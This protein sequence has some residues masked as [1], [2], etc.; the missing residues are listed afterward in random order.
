LQVCLC[1][2]AVLVALELDDVILG[3]AVLEVLELGSL[4][5]HHPGCSQTVEVGLAEDGACVAEAGMDVV[6]GVIVSSA[7]VVVIV[8][9][10][11]DLQPNQPGLMQL[12]V[13]YV[14][15]IIGV[16]EVVVDDSSRHPHHPGVLHVDV[17]VY[18]VELVVVDLVLVVV[19]L[20]LLSKNFQL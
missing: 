5:P 14:V 19:S 1:G 6:G 9:L 2:F 17:L 4:H 12:V 15:V 20:P 8:T 7:V 13:V 10:T 11:S 3:N 16:V 18:V